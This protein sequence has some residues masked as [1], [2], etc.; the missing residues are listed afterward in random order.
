MSGDQHVQSQKGDALYGF[1][2]FNDVPR[3]F[4][5]GADYVAYKKGLL[6]NKSR[7]NVIVGGNIAPTLSLAN[8][9]EITQSYSETDNATLEQH[10]FGMDFFFY[11][12][13]FGNGTNGGIW[14]S[15]NNILSFGGGTTV[16]SSDDISGIEG[17]FL[18]LADREMEQMYAF[19][20]EH[21]GNY[22]IYKLIVL[23]HTL[24]AEEEKSRF[25]IRLV[26]ERKGYF[27]QWIEVRTATANP[28]VGFF[29]VQAPSNELQYTFGTSYAWNSSSSFVLASN[30]QGD[31][32][33]LFDQTH[34][35]I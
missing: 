14:W 28:T 30:S 17:I 3:T 18:G 19:P 16:S 24:G 15:T 27:R 4:K 20:V 2:E 22:D 34:L 32:W 5:S 10:V 7:P 23:Q 26:R 31:N 13:N 1:Y 6:A 9:Q 29:N 35:S 21:K 33:K 8:S 12:M 25:E 11:G